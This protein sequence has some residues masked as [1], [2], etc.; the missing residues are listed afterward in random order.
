[1]TLYDFKNK[2]LNKELS[3]VFVLTGPEYYLKKQYADRLVADYNLKKATSL[4]ELSNKLGKKTLTGGKMNRFIIY[5]ES[6][7][8]FDISSLYTED[9]LV[10]IVTIDDKPSEHVIYF[11]LLGEEIL[12]KYTSSPL[13]KSR[14]QINIVQNALKILGK[15]EESILDVGLAENVLKKPSV[16]EYASAIIVGDKKSLIRYNYIL[17]NQK[18]SPYAYILTIIDMLSIYYV[19]LQERDV[20]KGHNEAF[21]MGLN[22]AYSKYLRSQFVR[23][24]TEEEKAQGGFGNWKRLRDLRYIDCIK[25]RKEVLDILLNNYMYY[26]IEDIYNYLT[27]CI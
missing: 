21:K 20:F 8:D 16:E 19:Y 5:L 6:I 24:K 15:G 7:K 2:L 17:V 9:G 26:D 14:G 23:L 1:M 11:G 22:Y 4:A 18:E 12:R 27:F 25:K 10:I 13:L 3:G